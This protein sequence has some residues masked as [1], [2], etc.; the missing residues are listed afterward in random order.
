MN[1]GDV[2]QILDELRKLRNRVGKLENDVKTLPARG[3]ES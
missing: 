2:S 3:P 1:Q